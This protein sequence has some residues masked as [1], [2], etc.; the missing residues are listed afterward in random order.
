[1]RF[2]RCLAAGFTARECISG[3]VIAGE[4]MVRGLIWMAPLETAL[5]LLL[6]VICRRVKVVCE[7]VLR[8]I[9]SFRLGFNSRCS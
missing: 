3:T 2:A 8:L 1:M 5:T 7:E 4:C 9:D 6:M